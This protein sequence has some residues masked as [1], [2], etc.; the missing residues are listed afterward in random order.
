MQTTQLQGSLTEYGAIILNKT[1]AQWELT[2]FLTGSLVLDIDPHL[3]TLKGSFY[4]I[5]LLRLERRVGV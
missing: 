2:V 3:F 4:L 5:G 1:G